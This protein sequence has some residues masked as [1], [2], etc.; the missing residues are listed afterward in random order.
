MRWL[1]GITDAMNRNLDKLWEVVGTGR[2]GV[3]LSTG[4][5]RVRQDWVAERQQQ[6][7]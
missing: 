2:P 4:L 3:L 6:Q 7:T 1:E 5:Q